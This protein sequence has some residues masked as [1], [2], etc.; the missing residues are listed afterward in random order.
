MNIATPRHPQ[1]DALEGAK[2]KIEE[3][4]RAKT[5][6]SALHVLTIATIGASIALYVS[7]KKDLAIFIGLWPPTFQALRHKD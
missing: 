2:N 3:F 5:G 4:S 6:L 1:E 7:G